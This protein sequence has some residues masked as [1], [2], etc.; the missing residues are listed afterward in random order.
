[1]KEIIISIIIIVL[2]IVGEVVTQHYTKNTIEIL[3]SDLEELKEEIKKEEVNE[4]NSKD[5]IN[6]MYDE[7]NNRHRKLS[8]YIEHDE[9]EKV[10]IN[11]SG[12]DDFIEAKNYDEAVVEIDKT[13]YSL[14]HLRNKINFNL[15]NIF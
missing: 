6:F 12:I 8:Y 9:L 5:K 15:E 7:W 2:I 1:M 4:E 13:N 3:S 11:F 14:N 10:E